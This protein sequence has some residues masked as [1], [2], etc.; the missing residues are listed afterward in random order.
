[1]ITLFGCILLLLPF[2]HIFFYKDKIKCFFYVSSAILIF[3]LLTV[4]ILQYF[5][6]FTYQIVLVISILSCLIS[7]LLH[8]KR[9]ISMVKVSIPFIVAITIVGVQFARVHYEYSGPVET[10][11]GVEHV[12][13]DTYMFPLFSDEWI[14]SGLAQYSINE[15]TLPTVNPFT[16]LKKENFLIVHSSL[17]AQFFLITQI[18]PVTDFAF[19][20]IFL[21]I[22][23]CVHV[24]M[25]LRGGSISPVVSALTV[26]FLPLITQAGN[27]PGL[28]FAIACIFSLVPYFIFLAG[29]LYEDRYLYVT[30]SLLA[31]IIYPPIL[32][33]IVPAYILYFFKKSI[34]KTIVSMFIIML[35][36]FI[37]VIFYPSLTSFIVRANLDGGIISYPFFSIMPMIVIPFVLAG[38]YKIYQHKK[39]FMLGPVVMGL[40]YWIGYV[41]FENVFVIEYPRIVMVASILL[42]TYSAYGFMFIEKWLMRPYIQAGILVCFLGVTIYYPIEKNWSKFITNP[43]EDFSSTRIVFPSMPINRYVKEE[44]LTIFKDIKETSFIAPPWK[45]LVIGIVTPNKPLETKHSIMRSRIVEYKEFMSMSCEQ[46]NRTMKRYNVGY[47]YSARFNCPHF[48]EVTQ[49][50]EKLILYRFI[51]N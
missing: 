39:Y 22:V 45:G 13:K 47:V 19:F 46:K 42:V 50:S 24:Y 15:S 3:N 27:L 43:S 40:L 44:D 6:I 1:M 38:L 2:L 31:F 37:P 18:H 41:F 30:G 8:K 35:V 14:V 49:T 20:P 29:L 36:A 32:V 7:L 26:L 5:G 12:T 17:V 21:G 9:P 4:L 51:K 16:K 11:N 34:S 48:E 25:F 33:C 23:V 28:W 10:L